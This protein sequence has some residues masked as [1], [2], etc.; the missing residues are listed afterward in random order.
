MKFAH[1]K[2]HTDHSLV[3]SLIKVTD[4]TSDKISNEHKA[5]ALTDDSF[6]SG[7]VKFYS[8]S[9]NNNLKPIIGAEINISSKFGMDKVVVLSKN[10]AG[11]KHILQLLTD[12]QETKET[13]QS[14]G[15]VELSNLL[16]KPENIIVLSGGNN[17]LL[18]NLTS[19]NNA[20]A[21]DYAKVFKASLGDNYFIELNRV[22]L[23]GEAEYIVAATEIAQQEGIP[24]VATNNVRFLEKDDYE[25]HEIRAA[26]SLKET[27]N[28]MRNKEAIYTPEQYLKS[29][30]EMIE[31]F[32]DIPSAISNT[33]AIAKK[34]NIEIELGNYYLPQ[35]PMEENYTPDKYLIKLAKEGLESR[36]TKLFPDTE[37]RNDVRKEYDDRL[38]RELDVINKMGFASY[39]I[40]VM[41]F[42][43]W[44]KE[45]Q[46]PVGAGRGSGAGSLV[47]Y[48][49]LITDIDPL[50]YDLLF[51][52]FLNPER[53]SMPDFDIDFCKNGRDKVIQHVS[54]LYGKDAVSQIITFGTLAA[55]ASIKDVGRV[56]GMSYPQV[57]KLTKLIP[58]T[59]GIKLEDAIKQSATLEMLIKEDKNVAMVMKHALKVEGLIRQVGKH[60]GGV[61]I[62][63]NTVSHFSSIYKET[64]HSK[65]VCQYDKDDIENVGPVKFDFLG[66][67]TL[68]VI[69]QALAHINK[70]NTEKGLPLLKV[71][72]IPLDDPLTYEN[73][74]SANT[75]GVFQLESSGMKNII[76]RL[77]PKNF[78]EVIALVALYR[79]G[80]LDSGMVDTFINCKKGIEDINYP[81]ACLEPI[82]D[83]TY[84]VFVYQEQ[85]MQ[86]AQIMAGYS[87]GQAD[88]LRRAMGK[89]K[90]EEMAKQRGMFTE[91]AIKHGHT[92]DEAKHVFDLMETFAGYGFNKSHSAGYTQTTI[93][94][95]YIKTHYP[96]AFFAATLTN[97]SDK[98]EKLVRTIHDANKNNVKIVPPCVNRS[99]SD[100]SVIDNKTVLFGLNSISGLGEAKLEVLL[101]DRAL[102]NDYKDVFDLIVRIN[103]D[104]RQLTALMYSGALDTFNEKRE[105]LH[106]Y[107]PK[108]HTA[109]K[110]GKEELKKLNQSIGNGNSQPDMFED[111]LSGII[112]KYEKIFFDL[113][114]N[115]DFQLAISK[116]D[117]IKEERKRLGLY[118]SEHPTDDYKKELKSESCTSI[119]NILD[120]SGSDVLENEKTQNG[121]NLVN[122]SGAITELNISNNRKGQTAKITLDD[123]TGQISLRLNSKLYNEIYHMLELDEV[124]TVTTL[125]S[126][127]PEKERFWYKPIKAKDVE[128][129]RQQN[130]SHITLNIDLQNPVKK[131][132]MKE[133]LS[134]TPKGTFRLKVKDIGST[135][136]K[137]HTIGEGRVVNDEFL[138]KF[139]AISDIDN[140]YEM[141]FKEKSINIES[142]NNANT[143]FENSDETLIKEELERSVSA[144][145]EA[146]EI[147]GL[148][149]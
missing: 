91:G 139:N 45:N 103:P 77:Q 21:K 111:S 17:S 72:D 43:K 138:V 73:L 140:S 128:M 49:L 88:L 40:I 145:R 53:V 148:T 123:G 93:V 36:L 38:Q 1:L 23:S 46:I 96:A 134:Q 5:I 11:Y 104:I 127:S 90:P 112:S 108:F 66:L 56:L 82:L 37:K 125:I 42:I 83:V 75:T 86:A 67:K 41:E 33:V 70:E 102:N 76:L 116:L 110:K 106:M 74:R 87:L 85:V 10:N 146:K 44:S 19:S 114:D 4:L 57:N 133:L 47:A 130:I 144:I 143:K 61:I 131:S 84:G 48:S 55:K 63:P 94:T 62:V 122:I 132:S 118:M 115:L 95:M 107:V 149:N 117:L 29:P 97:D 119:A 65:P 121:Q 99:V 50:E 54:D 68:T 12:S 28:S 100:F 89:K 31:L 129:I 120:L 124:L 58:D 136:G 24:V 59:N 14:I 32:K 35:S 30:D 105:H 20:S 9:R 137:I 18:F 25:T 101:K 147:M 26:I 98:T 7:A 8:K 22:G 141:N 135:D 142:K 3:D 71:E 15:Y 2:V 80:P 64:K 60:A 126:Y 52:R 51:E 78:E 109:W 39:F 13:E 34:C 69:D 92:E 16:S 27:L 6:I 81:H 113:K 79:P